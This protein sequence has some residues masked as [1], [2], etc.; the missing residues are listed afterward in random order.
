MKD[1]FNDKT[2][3]STFSPVS[4]TLGCSNVKFK[5]LNSEVINMAWFEF[6]QEKGIVMD[7]WKIK[8]DYDEYVDGIQ[9]SNRLRKAM[10]WEESEYY[11]ELQ[12]D[13][14]QNE[15]IYKLF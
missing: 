12:D 10:L 11:C 14:I 13:K 3:L 1:L 9:L 7:D 6:L 5:K 8:Q 2:I 15:F 4:H